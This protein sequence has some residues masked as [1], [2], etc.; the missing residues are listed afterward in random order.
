[1]VWD[2]LWGLAGSACEMWDWFQGRCWDMKDYTTFRNR[3][4]GYV[5]QVGLP[6][7][8]LGV[9][10]GG[11]G[12]SDIAVTASLGRCLTDHWATLGCLVLVTWF[13]SLLG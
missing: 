8:P 2:R 3:R 6:C 11:R 12:G 4:F 1:M 10:G 7:R 5:I 9:F 13:A